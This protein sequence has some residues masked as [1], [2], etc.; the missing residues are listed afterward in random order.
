MHCKTSHLHGGENGDKAYSR[1]RQQEWS[2]VTGPNAMKR[3]TA[4][5]AAGVKEIAQQ[6]REREPTWLIH[7]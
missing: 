3:L 2:T 4:G 1:N 5:T 6:T 7:M